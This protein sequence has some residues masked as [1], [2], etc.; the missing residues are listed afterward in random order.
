M[1]APAKETQVHAARAADGT[2]EASI[3]YEDG[4][5]SEGEG[6]VLWDA[7]RDAH[8][9]KRRKITDGPEPVGAA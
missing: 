7:L 2:W 4:T 6:S 9:G 5:Y 1:T 3:I 8:Q